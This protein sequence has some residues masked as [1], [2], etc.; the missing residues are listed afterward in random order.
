[1][2]PTLPGGAVAAPFFFVLYGQVGLFWALVLRLFVGVALGLIWRLLLARP[3][4]IWN[5]LTA[6]LTL[7]LAVF[8]ALDSVRNSL[9][10]VYG[11]L[12]GLGLIAGVTVAAELIQRVRVRLQ[13][14]RT[15]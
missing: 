11:V 15:D 12:W 2:N 1:M 6:A 7:V 10:A 8:L 3:R 4:S 9:L 13:D 14:L 5:S